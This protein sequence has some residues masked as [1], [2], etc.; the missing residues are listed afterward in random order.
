MTTLFF[1]IQRIGIARAI[2]KDSDVL[3]LDEATSHLNSKT[4]SSIQK[5]MKS[6]LKDKTVLMIAPRLST[7]RDVEE[8]LDNIKNLQQK[9]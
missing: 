1:L 9:P 5:K 2:Y 3:V 7:L 8:F 4:E 6:L